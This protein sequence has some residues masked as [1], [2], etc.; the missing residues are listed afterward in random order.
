MAY[1]R[2]TTDEFE[3]QQLTRYGWELVTA[4]TTAREARQRVREYRA[5]DPGVAVRW[6]KVRVHI[7][8]G[9]ALNFVFDLGAP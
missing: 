6:R 9:Q 8:A 1:K 4:E 7:E 3:V 2:K 5:N